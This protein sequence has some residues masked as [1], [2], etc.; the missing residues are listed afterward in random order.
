MHLKYLVHPEMLP[1]QDVP[2]TLVDEPAHVAGGVGGRDEVGV[3]LV[4]GVART[5]QGHAEE[6]VADV[7]AGADGLGVGARAEPLAVGLCVV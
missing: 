7:V 5:P 4:A 6:G 2:A 3:A 1:L